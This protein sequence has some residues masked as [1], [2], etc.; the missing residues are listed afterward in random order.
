MGMGAGHIFGNNLGRGRWW[1]V[2]GWQSG[3][4]SVNIGSW[5]RCGRGSGCV[6]LVL[7]VVGVMVGWCCVD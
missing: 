3:L 5:D 4:R 1:R 2:F 7:V 6:V